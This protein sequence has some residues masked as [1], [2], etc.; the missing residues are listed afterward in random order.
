MP[1]F[2][3]LLLYEQSNYKAKLRSQVNSIASSIP[4]ASDLNP[5]IAILI[6]S[7]DPVLPVVQQDVL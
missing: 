2:D 4:H 6:C 7:D 5:N 3:G 1:W